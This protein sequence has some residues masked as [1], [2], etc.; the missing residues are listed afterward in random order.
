MR[1]HRQICVRS[2]HGLIALL[3]F[4]VTSL[5][6]GAPALAV[7]ITPAGPIQDVQYG[8][9]ISTAFWNGTIFVQGTDNL[10]A[11]GP[12]SNSRGG[13]SVGSAHAS[14]TSSLSPPQ[15]SASA[16]VSSADF[17]HPASAT[18]HVTLDYSFIT[19]GPGVFTTVDLIAK[20]SGSGVT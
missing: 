11:S 5:A 7:S 16:D 2:P 9:F 18:A 14:Y 3:V 6:G 13:S 8:G 12:P 4:T 1:T 10:T 19:T 17:F 15:V 20:G